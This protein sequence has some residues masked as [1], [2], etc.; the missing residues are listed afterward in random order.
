MAIITLEVASL[1]KDWELCLWIPS[2]KRG[3]SALLAL[4]FW[5]LRSSSGLGRNTKLLCSSWRAWLVL[6]S[7]PPKA[8][9]IISRTHRGLRFCFSRACVWV[10][11]CFVCVPRQ[12]RE[13][14]IKSCPYEIQ[15]WALSGSEREIQA[16]LP[17]PAAAGHLSLNRVVYKCPTNRSIF[18]LCSWQLAVFFNWGHLWTRPSGDFKW[19]WLGRRSTLSGITKAGSFLQWA[20][21][22]EIRAAWSLPVRVKYRMHISCFFHLAAA[23]TLA[24]FE[25][26]WIEYT[27]MNSNL[28]FLLRKK[29]ICKHNHLR[30][31]MLFLNLI[32]G[33]LR[34]FSDHLE[35]RNGAI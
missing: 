6:H 10:L 23:L 26:T 24:V 15:V 20:G 2:R 35:T 8:E 13:S 31:F 16:L 34:V 12:G 29:Q 18:I 5:Y 9:L 3:N 17:P 21:R 11:T 28:S 4:I 19:P 27:S 33:I 32:T 25:C 22:G 30:Y 7:K 1:T 14:G